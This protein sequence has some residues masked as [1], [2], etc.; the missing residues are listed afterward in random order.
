M[1]LYAYI[2]YIILQIN[3]YIYIMVSVSWGWTHRMDLMIVMSIG[4][5]PDRGSMPIDRY[6]YIERSGN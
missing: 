3:T 2:Y 1:Q 4:R 5:S 6:V